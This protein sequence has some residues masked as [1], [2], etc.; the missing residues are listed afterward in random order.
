MAGDRPRSYELHFH[1]LVPGSVVSDYNKIKNI[2]KGSLAYPTSL[3][4][5]Q[6]PPDIADFTGRQP[7]LKSVKAL[8]RQVGK[9]EESTYPIS[10]LTGMA[11][12]G[13]SAIAIHAAH[14]LKPDFPDAQLY[15]NLR[16]TENQPLEPLEV[17]TS[18]I[19]SLGVDNPSIPEN[20]AERSNFYRSLLS[21]KRAL[22]VL[23]N[24]HDESQVRPLL[25]DSS[26][27]AVIVTT[28]A[29]LA[30]L[31]GAATLELEVMTEQEALDL[32]QRFIGVERL[33]AERDAAINIIDLCSR[34]PLAI[35]ITGGTLK[36][37]PD[38]RLEDCVRMLTDERQ[39][40]LKLRLS[41]LAVR[42][43][44]TLSYQE[45]DEI[46]ARLFRLLG[47]LIGSNFIGS[48]FTLAVATALLESEAAIAEESVKHLVD[49]QLLEP[50][51]LGRYRFHDLVRL[52]TK[53]QLA[54]QEPSEARHAARL[55]MIR[56][57]LETSE[58]MNLALNLE[59]RRQL[60][61]VL[62][63]GNNQS[64]EATEQDLFLTAINWFESER[65]N[66]LASIEWA[67]Q[68]KV[69]EIVAPL[70]KN[71][72]NF[73]SIH[74]YQADWERIHLLV[75]QVTQALTDLPEGDTS[76]DSSASR[77]IDAQTLVN[78]GNIHSLQSDWN[79]A[80]A[81]Y[82]KSLG[83]FRELGN[84]LGVAQTLGNL[85][86]VYSQQGNWEKASDRYQESLNIF[87]ELEDHYEE[88]QTL[89]NLGIL[90]AQQNN[91]EQ[92]IAVWREALG[93]LPS[94]LPR[95][96]Q[97]AEWLKS[98][99][100]VLVEVAENSNELHQAQGSSVKTLAGAIVVIAIAFFLIF[101]IF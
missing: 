16:G 68:A 26:T 64:L 50:S 29:P 48:N 17:L 21:G 2:F 85:A 81:C 12:I 49:V 39:R 56:W 6:F 79:K 38:W 65:T 96:K 19:R 25:P 62:V 4:L 72:V 46:P 76:E 101:V 24:A 80:N 69:W 92:A 41:D 84:S 58:M 93:K 35:R 99:G 15:V 63:Q 61:K 60:A 13:K 98:N 83:I 94:D 18:F 70:A 20:L 23:D 11:G 10:V 75:L 95:S 28:R 7:E 67:Y 22:V 42:V 71:L 89:A 57:Y 44:L 78:L 90:Y 31:E 86:N 54:Q 40:L 73:Y 100:G 30:H 87:G 52:F 77:H 9:N 5:H 27:C 32:L 53:G 47:L 33:Q 66:L 88:G 8:L 45:L 3:S 43:S 97:V 34:L 74:A 37:K 36:N 59:T 55:R 91:E 51:S 1:G 14:E 82:E